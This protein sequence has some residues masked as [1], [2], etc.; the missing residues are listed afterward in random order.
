MLYDPDKEVQKHGGKPPHWQQDDSWIFITWRLFDSIPQALLK[1]WKKRQEIWHQHHPKPWDKKT[2]ALFHKTFSGKMERWLDQGLGSCLLRHP[3]IANIV[4]ETLHHD[5]DKLYHLDSFVI[6]PNHV[7]LFVRLQDPPLE[8]LMQ[9]FKS[10]SAHRINKHLNRSGKVWQK[11]Y[12]DRLLRSEAHYHKVRNYI[13]ANPV[14]AK[15]SPDDFLL[16]PG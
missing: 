13:P 7:H 2:E 11:N 14:K 15:L 16:W 4:T 1:G 3:G 8:K 6:M 5:H 10:V 9:T 12:W